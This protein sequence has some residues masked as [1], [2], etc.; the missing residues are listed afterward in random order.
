MR[1]LGGAVGIALCGAILNSHTNGHFLDIASNLTAANNA[2]EHLLFSMTHQLGH[3]AALHQLHDLAY[4]E[5]STMAYADAFR[6]MTLICLAAAC[7]VPLMK[8]IV[9]SPAPVANAH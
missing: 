8:R 1:N 4:R 2:S 6:T 5:A 7:V 3:A 9:V